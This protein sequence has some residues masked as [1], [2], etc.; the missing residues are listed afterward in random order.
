[1]S[2]QDQ[3]GR[4]ASPFNFQA[5]NKA[6]QWLLSPL[7]LGSVNF[8]VDCTWSPLGFVVTAMLWAWSDEDTLTGRFTAARKICMKVLGT[9]ALGSG[10]RPAESYQAF[11][12]MMRTWTESLIQ[13]V[14]A[15][16]R[17]HM[18]EAL[19]DRFKIAGFALFGVDGT[20]IEVPRTASN[21]KGFSPQPPE[22]EAPAG[23]RT[24]RRYR[25]LAKMRRARRRRGD[26]KKAKTPLIW[27][28][29]MWHIG[30]GLPWDWRLGPSDSI[31]RE[32]LLEMISCLPLLALVVADAGF[33]GYEY[34]KAVIDSNRHFLI[35][36]GA[37]VH[38]LRGLGY[39][40]NAAG[41]V[42]LWPDHVA[43][44]KLP[45]LELRLVKV[46]RGKKTWYLVTSVLDK[47]RLPDWQVAEIYRRRW[48]IELFYRHFKQTFG[49]RKLRSKSADNAMVEAHWSLLGLWA[50]ALHTQYVL[51]PNQIPSHRISVAKL[52]RAH[53]KVMDQY[54]SRP[55]GGQSLTELLEQAVT[56]TYTRKNKASRDYP[57][58]TKPRETGTPRITRATR[59]QVK[60]AQQFKNKSQPV[61]LTA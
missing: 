59:A 54:Q 28:T 18:C 49:R 14:A 42:Y 15:A 20:R 44:K 23:K 39:T 5:L 48:G 27:L 32:H 1:M 43:A 60:S 10:E 8:R 16:F 46:R 47:Q 52:L 17:K 41:C 3:D 26:E 12:K 25:K 24:R 4:T 9:L 36:V 50:M 38:L 56:D 34:W 37:N 57:R 2:H 22:R 51:A 6:I 61:R 21:E 35:R 45:P 11:M 40:R 53:R 19:R 30:T 13:Q 33:V 7:V 31:E 55:D 29:T 58:K